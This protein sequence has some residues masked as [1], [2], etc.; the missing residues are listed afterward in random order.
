MPVTGVPLS[1]ISYCGSA[2]LFDMLTMGILLNISR[3]TAN[4]N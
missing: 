3:Q 4:K 1:F 2:L